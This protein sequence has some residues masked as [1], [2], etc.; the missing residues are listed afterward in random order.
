M[1]IPKSLL[2]FVLMAG[3]ANPIN[4]HTYD[5]YYRSGTAAEHA[6]D[7]KLAQENFRRAAINARIGHLGA[8]QEGWATYEWSRMTGHLGNFEDSLRGFQDAKAKLGQAYGPDSPKLVPLFSEM[9]RLYQDNGYFREA[10]DAYAAA[11]PLLEQI[12]ILKDDPI[13]YADLLDD[14][15]TCLMNSGESQQAEQIEAKS[16]NI[17]QRNWD[18]AAKQQF[19]RY[20]SAR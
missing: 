13:G 11:M 14:Y 3:C 15:A 20:P 7:L 9:G 2:M 19:R 6:N 18:V 16:Q 12:G 17:R 10:A 5:H 8:E 4:E 1:R